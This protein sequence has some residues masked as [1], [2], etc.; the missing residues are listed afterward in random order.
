MSV[1]WEEKRFMLDRSKEATLPLVKVRELLTLNH[2]VFLDKR[3]KNFETMK[4]L[5][6]DTDDVLKEVRKLKEGDFVGCDVQGELPDADV[7]IK[8]IRNIEMYVKF[9]L[10]KP[11]LLLIS[12][13]ESR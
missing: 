6:F 4:R 7:Y 10:K 12:F 3:R 5:G 1:K 11:N 2:V 13:H 8:T 9:R